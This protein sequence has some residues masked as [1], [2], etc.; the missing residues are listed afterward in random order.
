VTGKRQILVVDDEP[1]SLELMRRILR[2]IADVRT[3]DSA[4]EA[5]EILQEQEFDLLITDQ[6]MPGTQGV[7]LLSRVAEREDTLGR[8]LLT[9]YT[10]LA[11][12]TDA[13]NLGQ[14]HGYLR[15]PCDPDDVVDRVEMVLARVD[16]ARARERLARQVD[17]M[18]GTG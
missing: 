6:R 14:V 13:I 12:I 16:Q 2:P 9:G 4:E 8:I 1:R 18:K 10:D 15:K 17:S 5:W 11:S 3:A 7:D